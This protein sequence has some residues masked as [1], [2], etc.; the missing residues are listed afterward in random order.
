[1]NILLE[2]FKELNSKPTA[3]EELNEDLIIIDANKAKDKLYA[4]KDEIE[5]AEG[6]LKFFLCNLFDIYLFQVFSGGMPVSSEERDAIPEGEDE[7]IHSDLTKEEWDDLSNWR[8][9]IEVEF[10]EEEKTEKEI[11]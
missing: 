6:N 8:E 2:A 5:K 10:K 4:L 9:E 1:M 7:M 11:E 3:T